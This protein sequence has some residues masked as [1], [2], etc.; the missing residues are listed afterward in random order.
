MAK[1]QVIIYNAM[2][3][4]VSAE[5][6]AYGEGWQEGKAGT[7]RSNNPYQNMPFRSEWDRGWVKGS[8]EAKL[9][10]HSRQGEYPIGPGSKMTRRVGDAEYTHHTL[11]SREE[12]EAIAA[13]YRPDYQDV[14]VV[15]FEPTVK[16]LSGRNNK[17]TFRISV[18]KLKQHDAAERM[19]NSNV[20]HI[21]VRGAGGPAWCGNNRAGF[22]FAK[23]KFQTLPAEARCKNCQAKMERFASKREAKDFKSERGYQAKIFSSN[24]NVV[25]TSPVYIDQYDAENWLTKSLE[26]AKKLG[27]YVT[28]KTFAGFFDPAMVS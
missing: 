14:K 12:A 10:R 3:R 19:Y 23:E 22:S 26:K 18:G 7:R 1:R 28:G 9:S 24:G 8:T 5:E 11:R 17:S 25:G 27:F 2:V 4:D 6:F 16:S 20:A 21:G 13:K 15:E